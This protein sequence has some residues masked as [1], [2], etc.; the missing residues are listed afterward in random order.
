L[1][2]KIPLFYRLLLTNK[3]I[4]SQIVVAFLALTALI[5]SLEVL[6]YNWT[7]QML[8]INSLKEI[9]S[10]L[11]ENQM[12]MKSATNDFILREKTNEKF[13]AS[14]KSIFLDR[15][16]QYLTQMEKN[17]DEIQLTATQLNIVDQAELVNLKTS[18]ESYKESFLQ[19]VDKIKLRGYGRFGLIGEFEKS[20][21]ELLRFDFGADR[22]AVFKLQLFVKNYLL[23]GDENISNNI[24][25]EIYDFTMVLENHVKDRDVAKVSAILFNYETVFMQLVEVD[26]ALGIYSGNGLQSQLFTTSD[27]F[28]KVVRLEKINA[29]ISE[30]YSAILIKLYLRFFLIVGSALAAALSINKRLYR[31]LVVPIRE[32]KSIITRMSYGE[33]PKATV[34]FKVEELNEIAHALNNL[35]AGTR[36]HQE[37][38]NNIG[39]GNFTTN[40]TPV[41]DKDILGIS[42]LGMRES[43]KTNISEQHRQLKE[44]KKV[45]AELDNFIYHASHDIR[46]PLASIQGL[47]N[48]GSKE[49]SIAVALS[50]FQMIQ[51][52][53]SHMD[54]LLKDLIS[55]SYNN[56]AETKHQVFDFKVE[57][58]SLLKSLKSPGDD[59]D[60]QLN[61][62]Q[63]G[64]FK[65]DPIRVRTILTN[66]LSN[67]FKYYNPTVER[68]FIG[69]TIQVNSDSASVII[70]DNGIGIDQAYTDKIYDMFF[71]ATT[72]ST[73]TGLGLYIVKSM[74]DRLMGQISFETKL[75]Q[76]TTFHVIIPNQADR[77]SRDQLIINRDLIDHL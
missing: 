48:L 20:I 28:D 31:T 77:I 17:I 40:F 75:Y 57:M 43:L 41:S 58:N 52:R 62:S 4:S 30:S 71:R 13:F 68:H 51:G 9:S 26:R 25:N 16:I 21:D 42:L 22:T 67:S 12:E 45:N 63:D 8:A 7:R 36:N 49:K 69:V 23:T 47:A 15:Y 5:I 73:G 44:L 32:I 2:V 19:M 33:L 65:S 54:A 70:M 14:G 59:F 38:A 53:V 39:K 66:L 3:S 18:I 1:A 11:K 76:G 74:V 61:I 64:L 50:Y 46:A 56:K 60:I 27:R 34:R 6:A 55:I 24:S 10:R 35:I 72:L 29:A 37:F